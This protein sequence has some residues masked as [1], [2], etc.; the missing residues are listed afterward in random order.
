MIFILIKFCPTTPIQLS[1]FNAD[2]I[3]DIT[4]ILYNVLQLR[5]QYNII[6]V[7]YA[8]VTKYILL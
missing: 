7:S 4:K 3:L 5:F 8:C 2:T 6:C 1:F